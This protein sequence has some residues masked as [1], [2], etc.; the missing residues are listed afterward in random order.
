M[1]ESRASPQNQNGHHV[2][3]NQTDSTDLQQ[4]HIHNIHNGNRTTSDGVIPLMPNPNN[5]FTGRTE[6]IAKLKR[7]FFTNTNDG[8]KK[9]KFFLLHGMGGI[10]KTQICLKFVDEMSDHTITQALKGICNLS[11][12]Q[13][14][15][16]DGSPESALCWIGLLKEN[17]AMV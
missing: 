6:V 14:S 15:A 9:R 8:A 10:G 7:H 12:A 17:Y 1:L 11:E 2:R 3:V 16:L 5:R 4:M 13:L